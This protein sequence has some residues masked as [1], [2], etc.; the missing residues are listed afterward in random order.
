VEVD[1]HGLVGVL[2]LYGEEMS[3]RDA[4]TAR[5]QLKESYEADAHIQSLLM[6]EREREKERR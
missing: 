6:E 4:N 5:A 2:N 1:G 3:V